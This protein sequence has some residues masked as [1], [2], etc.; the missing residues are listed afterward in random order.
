MK[1][2]HTSFAVKGYFWKQVRSADFALYTLAVNKDRV[3]KSLRKVPDRLYNYVTRLLL[4]RCPLGDATDRVILTIDRSKNKAEQ[5][6]FNRYL[7]QQVQALLPPEIPLNIYHAASESSA[8]IQAADLFCWG[9]FRKY[10]VG[11][12]TWYQVFQEKILC[13]TLFLPPK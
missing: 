13:E 3:N 8:G 12:E 1:G 11:D 10:E 9:I 4:Q 2:T 6:D 5:A 7:T